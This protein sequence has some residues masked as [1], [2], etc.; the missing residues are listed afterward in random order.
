MSRRE[1]NLRRCQ[2]SSFMWDWT[3]KLSGGGL[4]FDFCVIWAG[5]KCIL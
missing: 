4:L 2:T 5:S 3:S 1:G